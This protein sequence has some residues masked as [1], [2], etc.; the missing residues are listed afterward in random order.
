MKTF[1]VMMLA[2]ATCFAA[3]QK[4]KD[5]YDIR[6]EAAK[7][8]DA[9]TSEKWQQE[10]AAK[11]AELTKTEVLASFVKDEAAAAALLK[12]VK[13]GYGTCP[14]KAFQI[15]AVTQ[16]V[17][18]DK[19]GCPFLGALAF[20]NWFSATEREVW[21]AQLLAFAEK[22]EKNDVKMYF[23]DQLRWCGYPTQA[24]DI[25]AIKGDAAVS[26]FAEMVAAELEGR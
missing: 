26:G 1:V 8:A 10:N 12:E 25:R 16:Y 19:G 6:P 17:M 15:A 5:A 11:L 4:K 22:S 2:A 9:P 23:L 18:T 24:K 13:T 21:A 3:E 7:S 14:E 20:W